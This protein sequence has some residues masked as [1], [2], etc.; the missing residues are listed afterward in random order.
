[1]TNQNPVLVVHRATIQELDEA[2]QKDAAELAA[3]QAERDQVRARATAA[4]HEEELREEADKLTASLP[5]LEKD[6]QER[7]D[8]MRAAVA[9]LAADLPR[10]LITGKQYESAL[11]RLE[12]L[13]AK[14]LRI[15]KR[16]RVPAFGGL[17]KSQL[18]QINAAVFLAANQK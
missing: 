15:E 17:A 12:V 1:M 16:T 9:T 2:A 11:A 13:R 4:L 7:G 10:L 5:G 6:L 14:G 18:A 3:R 8:R